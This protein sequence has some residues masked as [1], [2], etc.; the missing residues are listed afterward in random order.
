[1]ERYVTFWVT[2]EYPVHIDLDEFENRTG[3]KPTRTNLEA[4]ARDTSPGMVERNGV[5]GGLIME[6]GHG[7]VTECI[8]TETQRVRPASPTKVRRGKGSY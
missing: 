7:Q 3:L 6:A 1:M 2:R 4:Y 8:V 5:D